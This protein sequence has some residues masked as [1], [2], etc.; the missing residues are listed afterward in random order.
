MSKI[1]LRLTKLLN[2]NE[3]QRTTPKAFGE[4]QKTI[5]T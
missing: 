2:I 3:E 5:K 4:E 1:I